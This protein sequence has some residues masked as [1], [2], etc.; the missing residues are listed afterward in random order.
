MC[1]MLLDGLWYVPLHVLGR[2]WSISLIGWRTCGRGML[3]VL[4]VCLSA[5]G[6]LVFFLVMLNTHSV[7]VCPECCFLTG[8]ISVALASSMVSSWSA[9]L[10]NVNVSQQKRRLQPS[11]DCLGTAC[12]TVHF[13][14]DKGTGKS[15]SSQIS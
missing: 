4:L 7:V 9:R 1:V 15:Q 3:G 10:I 14:V 12:D 11:C 5:L 8:V 6:V 2:W 13:D